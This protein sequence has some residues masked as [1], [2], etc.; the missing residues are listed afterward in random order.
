M[1]LNDSIIDAFSDRPERLHKEINVRKLIKQWGDLFGDVNP[2]AALNY[3]NN[4]GGDSTFVFEMYKPRWNKSK[5]K[6]SFTAKQHNDQLI[7][8]LSN[9]G[10]DLS[11]LSMKHED[12]ITGKISKSSLFIDTAGDS[13]TTDMA[14][15]GNMYT[16]LDAR[17]AD[18]VLNYVLPADAPDQLFRIHPNN[19]WTGK[20]QQMA[21]IQDMF[22]DNRNGEVVYLTSG[23]YNQQWGYYDSND[24]FV[25]CNA[26]NTAAAPCMAWPNT[27][28]MLGYPGKSAVRYGGASPTFGIIA[29]A[30]GG[31][32]Y[33]LTIHITSII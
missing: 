16:V 3:E 26:Q 29:D 2:N 28:S 17:D 32:A 13:P 22:N 11:N 23:V 25:D 18:P 20:G 4:E 19:A 5:G 21:V 9:D 6:L 1:N 33:P 27:W 31:D 7:E 8:D 24:R 12:A 10:G 14:K 30:N 15:D